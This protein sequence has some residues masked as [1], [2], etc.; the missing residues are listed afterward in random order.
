MIVSLVCLSGNS[1]FYEACLSQGLTIISMFPLF[2]LGF[3]LQID[4]IPKKS[5]TLFLEKFQNIKILKN[6]IKYNKIAIYFQKYQIMY[7]SGRSKFTPR[8][9]CVFQI[10]ISDSVEYAYGTHFFYRQ[11]GRLLSLQPEILAKN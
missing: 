3:N 6:P 5:C 1:E 9:F 4:L 8:L 11:L 7:T 10:Q 2:N